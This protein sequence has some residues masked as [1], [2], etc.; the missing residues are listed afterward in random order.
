MRMG[1]TP[2]YR[3]RALR[4]TD[5]DEVTVY[6]R[7]DRGKGIAAVSTSSRTPLAFVVDLDG[8]RKEFYR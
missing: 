3:R 2:F 7:E 4:P 6:G 1:T 8:S 5:D